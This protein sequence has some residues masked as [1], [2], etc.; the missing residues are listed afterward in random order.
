MS[1][2]HDEHNSSMFFDHAYSEF[3]CFRHLPNGGPCFL[4]AGKYDRNDHFYFDYGLSLCD[5]SIQN[6]AINAAKI[7]VRNITESL[8]QKSIQSSMSMLVTSPPD[9]DVTIFFVKSSLTNHILQDDTFDYSKLIEGPHQV[10]IEI[11][12]NIP[13]QELPKKTCVRYTTLLNSLMQ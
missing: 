11:L 9:F 8:Y 1:L 7:A 2:V 3:A 5:Y 12:Q 10:Q 4:I 6:I 13:I